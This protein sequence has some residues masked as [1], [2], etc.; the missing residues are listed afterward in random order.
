MPYLNL[1]RVV[2]VALIL[3]ER[4]KK[5]DAA[6]SNRGKMLLLSMFAAIA[7]ALIFGRERL[8]RDARSPRVETPS[9]QAAG[10]DVITVHYHE[11]KPFNIS[12]V[13]GVYGLCADPLRLAFEKA[14]VRYRWR[15]TPSKRQMEILKQNRG[16]DCFLGWFKNPAREKIAKYSLPIYQDKPAVALARS[17]NPDVRTGVSL[18]MV[19]SNPSLVL[20]KKDGYSYGKMVDALIEETR[21]NQVITTA[22]NVGM[23]HMIRARRADYFFISKEEADELIIASGFPDTDFKYVRFS[24]MP[25]GEKRYILFSKMIEDDV[26]ARVNEAIRE[27][28][29]NH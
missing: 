12:S 24:G 10:E 19:L 9:V 14:G 4:E 23:L 11:R 2:E 17:N 16:R 22:D 15:Q 3:K 21:P 20:L 8:F 26:V 1:Y 27:S 5:E 25:M 28:D 13:D 7:I 18:K 6:M 29:H